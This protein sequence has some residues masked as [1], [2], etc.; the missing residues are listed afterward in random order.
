MGV[1]PSLT[2]TFA[3]P[4]CAFIYIHAYGPL[5]SEFRCRLKC[6]IT[7]RSIVRSFVTCP[8]FAVYSSRAAPSEMRSRDAGQMKIAPQSH[9][10]VILPPLAD[11]VRCCALNLRMK[12]RYMHSTSWGRT[13]HSDGAS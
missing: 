6:Y 5:S 3:A 8:V 10:H 1:S 7:K 12:R 4:S 9:L 13:F 11:C 2:N